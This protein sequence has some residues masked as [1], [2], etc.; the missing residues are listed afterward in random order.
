MAMDHD[1]AIVP[2]PSDERYTFWKVEWALM[3]YDRNTGVCTRRHMGSATFG[4][5]DAAGIFAAGKRRQQFFTNTV[6]VVED[7]MGW[8]PPL[9]PLVVNPQ[10]G[11]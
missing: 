9:S 3:D 8:K 6:R 5:Q 11:R 10:E 1:G 2:W 7:S 4:R